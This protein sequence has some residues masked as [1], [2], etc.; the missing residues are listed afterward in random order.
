MQVRREV[1]LWEGAVQQ[2]DGPN[3]SR[4]REPLGGS[5]GMVPREILKIRLSETAFRAF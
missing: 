4:R 3:E 1:F 5:G 2:G